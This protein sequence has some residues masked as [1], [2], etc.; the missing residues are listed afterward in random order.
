MPDNALRTGL[1]LLGF[2]VHASSLIEIQPIPFSIPE[3]NYDWVFLSSKNAAQIFLPQFKG[4]KKFGVAGT[5]TAQTVKGFGHDSMF[6]GVGGDM[7]KVGKEFCKMIG[8][9]KVLFPMAEGG[10]GRIRN[11][12][13]PDQVIELPIYRTILL[14]NSAI[15]ETDIV[16]LT[17]PSNAQ[18]YLNSSIVAGKTIIAIGNTTRDFLLNA[19]LENVFM[20]EYPSQESVLGLIGSL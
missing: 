12:L 6:V 2:E 11:Q 13:N 17:S 8:D 5:A 3:S 19:G 15:P 9:T 16:F 20:P 1:E 10:S 14:G 7:K 4:N 18:A